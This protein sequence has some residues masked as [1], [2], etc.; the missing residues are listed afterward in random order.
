MRN[1]KQSVS[2]K[3]IAELIAEGALRQVHQPSHIRRDVLQK[4]QHPND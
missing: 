4:N 3:L 2:I 1:A